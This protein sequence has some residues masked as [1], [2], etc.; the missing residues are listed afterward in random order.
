MYKILFAKNVLGKDEKL[1]A[2]ASRK[3]DVLAV[4]IAGTQLG[5]VKKIVEWAHETNTKLYART[6]F[7]HTTPT[8]DLASRADALLKNGVDGLIFHGQ[9]VKENSD[10]L[11]ARFKE[12]AV[13]LQESLVT[14]PVV[15][16]IDQF[17]GDVNLLGKCQKLVKTD[18]FPKDIDIRVAVRISSKAINENT[19]FPEASLHIVDFSPTDDSQVYRAVDTAAFKN[20]LPVLAYMTYDN[21]SDELR[22]AFIDMNPKQPEETSKKIT[23]LYDLMLREIPNGRIVKDGFNNPVVILTQTLMTAVETRIQGGSDIWYKINL[24]G[25]TGW[26]AGRIGST[27][28]SK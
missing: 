9:T 20:N 23:A 10:D 28:Y 7:V 8:S 26:V 19:I 13:S 4:V 25:Y 2:F 1:F 17:A 18:E 11:I 3:F 21:M 12:L 16:M 22:N 15:F 14:K 27:D 6:I 5:N 24:P